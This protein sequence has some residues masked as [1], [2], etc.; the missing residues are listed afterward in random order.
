MKD[1]VVSNVLNVRRSDPGGRHSG[2]VLSAS[3]VTRRVLPSNGLIQTSMLR[4]GVA[5]DTLNCL[6]SADNRGS[7]MASSVRPV[8]ADSLPPRSTQT[9]CI[10]PTAALRYASAPLAST[11]KSPYCPV[12]GPLETVSPNSRSVPLTLPERTL[13]ARAQRVPFVFWKTTWP[14][15]D[16]VARTPGN[17]TVAS[18]VPRSTNAID[19]R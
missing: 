2:R 12:C 11:A 7:K 3:D 9:A 14:L 18:C 1:P 15:G 19:V 13:N 16:H 5:A 4:S 10:G 8:M 6:P 17:S